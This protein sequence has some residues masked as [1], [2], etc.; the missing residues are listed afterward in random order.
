[1]ALDTSLVCFLL[2]LT[3]LLIHFK[4]SLE[5]KEAS[6]HVDKDKDGR[7]N[8]NFIHKNLYFNSV[9]L[10]SISSHMTRQ[11]SILPYPYDRP[12]KITHQCLYFVLWELEEKQGHVNQDFD[13]YSNLN[14]EARVAQD[15]W[16][17][18]HVDMD[19]ADLVH[20]LR[21]LTDAESLDLGIKRE[22]KYSGSWKATFEG[23]A[24][25]KWE[26]LMNTP[27]RLALYQGKYEVPRDVQMWT[28]EQGLECKQ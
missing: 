28:E 9:N 20:Q 16:L 4:A 15:L 12:R 24:Q 14:E 3:K 2:S 6:Y 5:L 23:Q 1:M 11:S 17:H 27:A 25:E 10:V 13:L 26:Q 8:I 7:L 21:W 19:K 18:Q 22:G